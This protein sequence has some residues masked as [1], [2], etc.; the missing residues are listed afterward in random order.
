V[1]ALRE[2]YQAEDQLR[3]SMQQL[4]ESRKQIEDLK[5]QIALLKANQQSAQ[6]NSH[7][8]SAE[9]LNE[10]YLRT[11]KANEFQL[12]FQQ[13]MKSLLLDD[14]F[15]TAFASIHKLAEQGLQR[16]WKSWA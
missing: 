16:L 15:S 4:D 1:K 13:A 2:N 11:V 8:K 3:E 9:A 10:E 12:V 5:Q 14:D 6:N 7:G